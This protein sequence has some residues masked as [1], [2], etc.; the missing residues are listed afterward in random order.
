MGT[1][2]NT[3]PG[4]HYVRGRCFYKDD[5]RNELAEQTD[6]IQ[7]GLHAVNAFFAS[8]GRKPSPEKTK[9]VEFGPGWKRAWKKLT[10]NGTHIQKTEEHAVLGVFPNSNLDRTMWIGRMRNTWKQ[11]LYI[12]TRMATRAGGVGERVA[13]TIVQTALVS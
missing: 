9:Y 8:P 10:F 4:I 1:S 6:T 12:A 7:R 5:D 3:E 2:S 13:E 11:G